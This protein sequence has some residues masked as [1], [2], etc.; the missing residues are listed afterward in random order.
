MHR[1][2]V[3]VGIAGVAALALLGGCGGGIG[4]NTPAD[5]S[6]HRS[7]FVAV[8]GVRLHYLDWGGQGETLLFLPGLG[9]NAHIFDDLAPRFTNRYRVLALTR[10]GFGRSDQPA[11]GYD[12]DTLAADVKGLLDQLGI[13]RTHLVGHS[14]AGNELTRFAAGYPERVGKLIYLD[15]A[16]D[17]SDSTPI[18]V[19]DP[20]TGEEITAPEPTAADLASFDALVAFG[21]RTDD[22]WSDAKENSLR[23]QVVIQPD[24][25]VL[26]RTTETV[27]VPFFVASIQYQAEYAKVQAP[28]LA[29]Y[30]LPGDIFDVYPFLPRDVSGRTREIAERDVRV[31]Q[32]YRRSQAA[33]FGSEVARAK[34]VELPNAVHYLFI[35]RPDEVTHEIEAF[36]RE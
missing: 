12:V 15:A 7:A 25:S 22:A 33:R 13:E 18:D 5:R 4:V 6:P 1:R 10:R 8:N 9:D 28:A 27:L 32:A 29:I 30:A 2:K 23:D 35:Q 21:K 3:I 24:G 36:L 26:P 20:Y 31:G 34:V 11:D 16:I 14:I 19:P 17:R